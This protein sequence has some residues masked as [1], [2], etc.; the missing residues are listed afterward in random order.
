MLL[1]ASL[2][3]STLSGLLF[4]QTPNPLAFEVADVRI[5]QSGLPGM[6]A[7]FLPGGQLRVTNAPMRM[8]LILAYH[9]QPQA[10]LGEPGWVHDDRFDIIAKGKPDSS[11]DDLRLMLQTLLMERFKL[12]AHREEK[13]MSAYALVVGKSAPKLKP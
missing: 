9:V 7:Q 5:N 6:S 3:L 12:V 2:L 13:I 1:R 11:E 4:S 8:L 10:L